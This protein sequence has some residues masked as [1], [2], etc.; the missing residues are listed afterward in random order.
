[1]KGSGSMDQGE[2]WTGVKGD[3]LGMGSRGTEEARRPTIHTRCKRTGI[4]GS[5]NIDPGF[6]SCHMA[7]FYLKHFH[8]NVS[9]PAWSFITP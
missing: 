2:G 3:K 7:K 6:R 8:P 9:P 4:K 1:M 5:V